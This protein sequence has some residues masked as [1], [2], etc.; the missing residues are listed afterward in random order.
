MSFLSTLN[1][2]I[3]KAQNPFIREI[4]HGVAGA[5]KG[6]TGADL[7]DKG[8]KLFDGIV[9]AFEQFKSPTKTVAPSTTS[10]LKDPRTALASLTA[11]SSSAST[12]AAETSSSS[13]ASTAATSSSKSA[14]TASS[15]NNASVGGLASSALGGGLGLSKFQ[16][17]LLSQSGF[18][19]DSTEYK[20]AKFQMQMANY[21]NM[22]QLLSNVSKMIS[23]MQKNI[24]SNIR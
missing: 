4:A 23:E 19:K 17:N 13:S 24:I 10:S 11:S 7:V 2:V 12:A 21:T 16:E 3:S 8:F 18:D 5:I 9:S 15:D 14:A 1:T 6:Q 20:Q 22:V